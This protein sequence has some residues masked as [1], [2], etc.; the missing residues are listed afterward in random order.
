MNVVTVFGEREVSRLFEMAPK[1]F[2]DTMSHWLWRERRNFVGNKK[3]QGAFR[4]HLGKKTRRDTGKPW[5]V[6]VR[7]AFSGF[8]NHPKVIQGMT[9]KMGVNEKWLK[10]MPYLEL[11][12]TGGT[13]T[14][15]R[16]S[17][18]IVPNYKNLRTV[19]EY[20]KYGG[21]GKNTFGK[22]FRK[23]YE[24]SDL[25]YLLFHGKMLYFGDFEGR[26]HAHLNDKLLFTG[27]KSA[28]IKRQF[29]FQR[30]FIRRRNGM[31]KR[32]NNMVNRTVRSLNSGKVWIE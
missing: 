22:L 14:P 18:M 9:L 12:G 31:V 29:D 5:S 17:W 21:H 7:N 32:A 10:R 25:H 2:A 11:L 1:V 15:K 3:K 28:Q 13:L 24:G 19:A 4:R 26:S 27:I 20:R 16:S 8:V 30:S 23:L 6:G